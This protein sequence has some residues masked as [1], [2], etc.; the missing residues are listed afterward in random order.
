[1]FDLRI[2]KFEVDQWL[3]AYDIGTR[4]RWRNEIMERF[5]GAM[6]SIVSA[7]N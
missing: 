1:M 3:E 7:K 4:A 5:E 6:E 2:C